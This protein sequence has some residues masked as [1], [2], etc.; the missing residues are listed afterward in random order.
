[1]KRADFAVV[2]D[3]DGVI[4][5]S[6]KAILDCWIL[7]A[8]KYQ[9][10]DIRSSCI[11]CLGITREESARVMKGIYGQEFPYAAYRD[12]VSGLF[13]NLYGEGRL[14][15]KT[16]A[17]EL[18]Q[19]LK[20]AG[21][22]TGLAS[23]TRREIV[24]QELS[25]AGI[26]SFFDRII[27]GDMVANSK[28]DPEIYRKACEEL[29]VRCGN[30]YAIE[31]SYNGIRSAFRAGLIPIMVPDLAPVTEEMEKLAKKIL[32]SLKEAGEFMFQGSGLTEMRIS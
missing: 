2:F 16:G 11:K 19:A 18:L 15:L 1:M 27:C 32:P 7:V 9:I 12:E 30:T 5:D 31:D 21:I 22:P 13:R 24:C 26:L 20:E 25:D 10:P 28:P 23:S 29:G 14:P 3:M 8:E 4:F 6:E 17:K